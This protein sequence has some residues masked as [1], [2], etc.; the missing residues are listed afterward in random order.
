MHTQRRRSCL[1]VSL[2]LLFILSLVGAKATMAATPERQEASPETN[3]DAAPPLMTFAAFGDVPYLI[4]LPNGRTDEQVLTDEIAP[5][6]RKR[7]DIPFVIHLGDLSRPEYSCSDAWLLKT[8]RFWEQ[9]LVK[10]VFYTPGDNDWADCDRKNLAVRQSELERLDRLR[11]IM[12]GTP[13]TF[14]PTWQLEETQRILGKDP[15]FSRPEA[16]LQAIRRVVAMGP[17][18]FAQEWRYE[19]QAKMP[20]NA[21]WWKQGVLFVTVHKIST[22][23]G[24]S[25]ILLDDPKKAI[26]LADERERLNQQWLNRAFDLAKNQDTK[27]IVVATQLDPF[28]PALKQESS[29]DHCLSN[30]AYSGFCKQLQSLSAGL[31][32]PVLLLHGDT[33]AYCLDQPMATT[34]NLWRLNAPGDFKVVDA[35]VVKVF[36]ADPNQ[37][38]QVTGL[39]SGTAPPAVCDYSK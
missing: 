20:E 36:P 38:F 26:A 7:D 27:A 35:A 8:K 17:E 9:K 23:D 32:K 1:S 21:I 15:L 29:L 2:I 39:L 10:P 18:Q 25:E 12:F 11:T 31:A 30:A 22:D 37:P 13:Q 5:T 4:K 33:N 34:R 6:L 19:R 28:G 14:S 16:T 24:R 3:R